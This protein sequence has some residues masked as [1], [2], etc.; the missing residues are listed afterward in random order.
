MTKTYSSCP[1]ITTLAYAPP[2]L[3]VTYHTLAGADCAVCL[4]RKHHTLL[5]DIRLWSQFAAYHHRSQQ[6][7][8]PEGG[9]WV[10]GPFLSYRV[11]EDGMS[12]EEQCTE[13]FRGMAEEL[14]MIVSRDKF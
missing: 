4:L 9:A 7:T 13:A 10:K 12:P 11:L 3:K 6:S 8:F 2:T 14:A 5:T 1:S